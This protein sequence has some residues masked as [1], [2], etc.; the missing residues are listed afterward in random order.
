MFALGTHKLFA[1]I[2]RYLASPNGK[3][4]RCADEKVKL[5]C[6]TR[7]H[8]EGSTPCPSPYSSSSMTQIMNSLGALLHTIA[9]RRNSCLSSSS[10]S[11]EMKLSA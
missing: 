2:L 10:L 3:A 6:V 4:N 7:A 1:L 5:T 11:Q 9:D 8:L